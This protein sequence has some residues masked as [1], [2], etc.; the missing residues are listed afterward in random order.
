MVPAYVVFTHAVAIF[1]WWRLRDFDR[2]GPEI[3]Q[4]DCDSV[5]SEGSPCI[6]AF[7]SETHAQ[8]YPR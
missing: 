2:A 5:L 1:V 3:V 4:Y 6:S 7:D 8:Y